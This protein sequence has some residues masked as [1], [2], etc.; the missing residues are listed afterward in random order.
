MIRQRI[1]FT[2]VRAMTLLLGQASFA[3]R[4]DSNAE[5]IVDVMDAMPTRSGWKEASSAFK[6]SWV[7]WHAGQSKT[8]TS[9][10]FWSSTAA[11]YAKA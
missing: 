6:F 7:K 9:K 5:G 11:R 2:A 10:P 8:L 1:K 4:A 3:T